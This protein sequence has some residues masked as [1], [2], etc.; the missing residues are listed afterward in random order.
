[1]TVREIEGYLARVETIKIAD[2]AFW[3]S[4]RSSRNDKE[5]IN[6]TPS[7]KRARRRSLSNAEIS[8]V[9]TPQ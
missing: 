7:Q 9:D 5:E 1:M 6:M 8:A 4:I 2:N 3:Q